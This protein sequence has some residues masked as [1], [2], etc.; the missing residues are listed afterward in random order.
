MDE[1][2]LISNE[3]H[4]SKTTYIKAILFCLKKDFANLQKKI[5][6]K[7]FNYVHNFHPILISF[8]IYLPLMIPNGT[9]S[10]KV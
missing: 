2:C 8:Q 9:F 1:L 3:H 7:K 6:N 10:L 4:F 5:Y